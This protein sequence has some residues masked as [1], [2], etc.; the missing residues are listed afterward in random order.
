LTLF[1]ALQCAS[2][3]C[4]A[5]TGSGGKTTIMFQLGRE[6]VLQGKRVIIST[7]TKIAAPSGKEEWFL[8]DK[9]IKSFRESWRKSSREP[10][11]CIVGSRLVEEDKKLDA[12]NME[13]VRELITW[14]DLDYLLIEADGSR[15][16]A[17]KGHAPYEP[18]IPEN[19]DIVIAV[20]G[21]EVLGHP[22][23]A[24]YVHRHE[25]VMRL[26]QKREGTIVDER[27][28]AALLVHREGYLGRTGLR[29]TRIILNGISQESQYRAALSIAEALH[30]H[31]KE[32]M[33]CLRGP[34]FGLSPENNYG[35]IV[36]K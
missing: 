9:G 22:L 32:L 20:A 15:G 34:L 13:T 6:L 21:L 7:T 16:K 5:L 1:E 23:S 24:E 30:E 4:I 3:K 12:I 27:D 35:H 11:L 10:A 25:I 2:G 17:L 8:L 26:L 36:L 18:V 14:E 28:V 31:S 19:C 33:V 29:E